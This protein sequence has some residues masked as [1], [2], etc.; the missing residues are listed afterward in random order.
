MIFGGQTEDGPNTQFD[1]YDL[2]CECLGYAETNLEMGKIF[3]PP[4]YDPV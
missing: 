1:I 2:T 4:V 3:L